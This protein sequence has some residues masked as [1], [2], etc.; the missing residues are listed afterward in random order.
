MDTEKKGSKER[1]GKAKAV[2]GVGCG[3]VGKPKGLWFVHHKD[4]FVPTP[5]SETKSVCRQHL[6]W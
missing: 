1:A 5:F 3:W 6:K 2:C 4:S